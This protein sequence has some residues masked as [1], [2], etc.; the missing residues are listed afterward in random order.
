[1]PPY[2]LS[3]DSP[4]AQ[5]GRRRPPRGQLTRSGSLIGALKNI[6][7]APLAWFTS[8]DDQENLSGKRSRTTNAILEDG[9]AYHEDQP[10]AKRKRVDS[11][12]PPAPRSTQG[13]LDVPDNLFSKPIGGRHRYGAQLGHGRSSS[14]VAPL[15]IPVTQSAHLARRTA[16]PAGILAPS[17]LA[18]TQRTQSMDPPQYRPLS[19]SRDVSMEDGQLGSATRDVTM[20]PSRR[21]PFQLRA[22]NSLTPRPTGQ[23][24]GP[25][26]RHKERDASEPPPLAALMSKPQFVK[27]PPQIAQA[28]QDFTTLGSLTE[29]KGRVVREKHILVSS[30]DRN[31]F[32]QSR[33]PMRQ[34]SG[35]FLG[36]QARPGAIAEKD[37]SRTYCY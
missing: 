4:R 18:T 2:L 35:L 5:H 3:R 36:V 34:H 9:G 30:S 12:E 27:P 15:S 17:Q 10:S 32:P 26:V 25:N 19:L 24:F 28:G 20:S 13:Y 22:R 1:M 33:S 6:V 11:P 14:M 7:S 31:R 23:T 8:Y 37:S 21:D 16:S 29:A